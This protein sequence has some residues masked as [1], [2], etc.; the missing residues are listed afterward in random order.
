MTTL[1]RGI[2]LSRNLMTIRLAQ[3]VGMEKVVEYPERFGAYDHLAPLL[4][5]SIGSVDTTLLKQVT[6]YSVFV[7]G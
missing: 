6:G 4:S 7:N 2:E 5:N 3:A 1:R